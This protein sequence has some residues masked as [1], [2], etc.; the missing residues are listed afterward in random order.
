MNR[1][2]TTSRRRC[3]ESISTNTE[4]IADRLGDIRH[5]PENVPLHH[6]C[7]ISETALQHWTTSSRYYVTMNSDRRGLKRSKERLIVTPLVSAS[8]EK[9]IVQIIGESKKSTALRGIG[10]YKVVYHHQ[11]KAWQ[12]GS[13]MLC[14]LH[15][16]TREAKRCRQM[17]FLLLDNCSSDVFS[18]KILAPN[19]SADS[20][21]TF[22]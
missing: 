18:A 5:R 15:R 10:T 4:T 19:G 11:S 14:L 9:L 17:F 8:G 12:E 2:R 20:S 7:N 16:I 6:I 13:S 1:K 21:F 3:V 22:E